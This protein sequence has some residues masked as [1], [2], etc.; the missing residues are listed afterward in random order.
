MGFLSSV[1]RGV[2]K[3]FSGIASGVKK[4]FKGIGEAFGKVMDSKWGKVLMVAMAVFTMGTA[5]IAGFQGFAST[6]GSFLTKFVAGAKEFVV[7]LANPV[8]KA[9][10]LFGGAGGVGSVGTS[11]VAAAGGDV[12]EASGALD[13][14]ALVEVASD[15][16]VATQSAGS[17]ISPDAI[18]SGLDAAGGVEQ[19]GQAGAQL[20]EAGSTLGQASDVTSIAE[21]ILERAV[22]TQAPAD[23]LD[24]AGKAWDYAT[25]DEG[26]ALFGQAFKSYSQGLQQEEL[27]KQAA[28]ERRFYDKAWRDPEQLAKLHEATGRR[29]EVP[30]N[31]QT[32]AVTN[33]IGNYQSRTIQFNPQG[34]Q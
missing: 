7:A 6:A 2:K 8:S 16:N 31:Y 20:G 24:Y 28:E 25:S 3:F 30:K 13:P 9:K 12:L 26:K 5:L 33:P 17:M 18:T 27:M 29:I 11:N 34:G 10:E 1:G 21:G 4:V 19:L 32:G 22:E 15:A 23:L 14:S